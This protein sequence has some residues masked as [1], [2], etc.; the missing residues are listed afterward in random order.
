MVVLVGEPVKIGVP[1][2]LHHISYKPLIFN[3]FFL[4]GDGCA[5]VIHPSDPTSVAHAK[6]APP[7]QQ[8]GL[9]ATGLDLPSANGDRLDNILKRLMP[10][11]HVTRHR[12]AGQP[13]VAP[14]VMSPSGTASSARP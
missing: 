1:P 10:G 4:C 6:P 11:G 12:A 13:Q 3:G 14:M 8:R 9:A 7:S 5:E 2:H